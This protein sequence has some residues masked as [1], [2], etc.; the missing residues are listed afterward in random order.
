MKRPTESPPEAKTPPELR[1]IEGE[2]MRHT[3]KIKLSS[4]DAIR[5]EM[6]KVYRE[7]RAGKMDSSNAAR[8][9]YML[10]QL[11]KLYESSVIE[12]RLKQLEKEV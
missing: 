1:V 4:L 9:T 5:T 7:V 3:P 10:A 2:V 11:G 8:L 6:A 12:R